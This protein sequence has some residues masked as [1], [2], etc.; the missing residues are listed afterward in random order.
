MKNPY[1]YAF[2]EDP[3]EYFGECKTKKQALA[4]GITEHLN[5]NCNCNKFI[6]AV[7]K[8]YRPKP[9]E[10]L[11]YTDIREAIEQMCEAAA[12]DGCF[13]GD[14]NLFEV[15]G[16]EDEA[17]KALILALGKWAKKYIE[18]VTYTVTPET[19]ERYEVEVNGDKETIKRITDNK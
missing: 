10:Y 15:K 11:P 19:V 14:D 7:G 5:E 17:E 2:G 8:C 16:D 4:D 18:A 3:E 12:D 1:C 13:G 9:E 6:I